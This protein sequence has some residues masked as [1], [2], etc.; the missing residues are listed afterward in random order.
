MPRCYEQDGW[1][2]ELVV[3]VG[4]LPAGKN[5]SMEAED[6]LGSIIRQQLVKMQQTEK[7]S[8]VL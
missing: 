1:S 6:I 7:T 2:S 5:V 4:W 8:Y 3:V